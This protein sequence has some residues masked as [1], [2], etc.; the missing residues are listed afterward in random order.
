MS[1]FIRNFASIALV[2]GMCWGGS[3]FYWRQ[4]A[5]AP[6]GVEILVMLG[7]LPVAVIGGG[8]MMRSLGQRVR[9][10][11]AERIAPAETATPIIGDDAVVD[12]MSHPCPLTLLAS[13]VRLPLALE[14][15]VVLADPLASARLHA[16]PIYRDSSGLPVYL[17]M[18]DGLD[19]SVLPP[20][21]DSEPA[22][23][24]RRALALLV[25]VAEDLLLQAV[26]AMP[27]LTQI[28]G[29][30]VAGWRQQIA[31]NVECQLT[32]ELLIPS[33]WPSTLRIACADWLQ[34][35]A[36]KLGID[37]RRFEVQVLPADDASDVW[38][39]LQQRMDAS[40]Q[41][42]PGWQL[43]LATHSLIGPASLERWE[44]SGRLRTSANPD[45]LVPGEAAA[46]VLLAWPGAEHEA[47]PRLY[48]TARAE[49]PAGTNVA[50]RTRCV[51]E[52]ANAL[53]ERAGVEPSRID[54]LISDADLRPDLA[55]EASSA[56]VQVCGD[57]DLSRQHIAL[58]RSSGEIGPVLPLAQLA[59]AHTHLDVGGE[60]V[61]IL[62]VS[63]KSMR[64][65]VLLDSPSPDQVS[66]GDALAADTAQPEPV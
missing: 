24:H 41:A 28:E 52:L 37:A 44:A 62:A 20:E 53:L 43:L 47:A 49:V 2:L 6:D 22:E 29:R 46:G 34:C 48:R 11:A 55:V 57:L 60:M 38:A 31:E 17:A 45:G 33:A 7:L 58:P 15:T 18:S 66:S 63:P 56:A 21:L 16:H 54:L 35:S 51:G 36:Q 8:W 32:I 30:V 3:I 40:M 1:A 61:M 5:S 12:K 64:W 65:A 13:A 39:R 59:L 27:A 50:A 26:Q 23:H 19:S 14:P 25:P 9:D 10:A 42:A 4:T